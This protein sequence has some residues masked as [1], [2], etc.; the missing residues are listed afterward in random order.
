[1]LFIIVKP[2]RG[3]SRPCL[4]FDGKKREGEAN[5]VMKEEAV[6]AG[7]HGD[8]G[9]VRHAVTSAS[10]RGANA[11]PDGSGGHWSKQSTSAKK[12]NLTGKGSCKKF[13][14]EFPRSKKR[15]RRRT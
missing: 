3:A 2:Q 8:N 1:V 4:S 13:V 6:G 14:R 5:S 12:G 7:L 9:A 15:G 11:D 10:G